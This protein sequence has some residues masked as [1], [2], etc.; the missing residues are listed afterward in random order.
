[1]TAQFPIDY[2][3]VSSKE[4]MQMLAA[5]C[6]YGG[7]DAVAYLANPDHRNGSDREIVVC[8]PCAG[9]DDTFIKVIATMSLETGNKIIR[10]VPFPSDAIK[11]ELEIVDMSRKSWGY[12]YIPP[13]G[14]RREGF[15]ALATPDTGASACVATM[16]GAVVTSIYQK[17]GRDFFRVELRDHGGS[18]ED[19]RHGKLRAVVYDGPLLSKDVFL[20]IKAA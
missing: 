7:N 1:M 12:V 14:R 5:A 11:K 13:C 15:S 3:I 10:N 8:A 2:D 17:D 18:G 6:G 9:G 16:Q 19:V 4:H 20:S